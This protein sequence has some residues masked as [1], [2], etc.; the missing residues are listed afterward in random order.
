MSEKEYVKKTDNKSYINLGTVRQSEDDDGNKYYRLV[1]D[2]DI[3]ILVGGEK[4]TLNKYRSINLYDAA[5]SNANL[6]ENDHITQAR[7]DAQNEFIEK[8]K[9]RY[10]AVRSP[11]KKKDLE[12]EDTVT[13]TK[14]S[15]VQAQSAENF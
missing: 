13:T 9:V 4:I 8:N 2:K 1:L 5:K 6:L 10:N 3:E 11:L 7:F 14:S 15:N 12:D